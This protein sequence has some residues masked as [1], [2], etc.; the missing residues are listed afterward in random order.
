MTVRGKRTAT[1]VT[2]KPCKKC[3]CEERYTWRD[4]LACPQCASN[5]AKKYWRKKNNLPSPTRQETSNCEC[6]GR[7]G[8]ICLDHD[9]K[10]GEFRGWLCH[11]CNLGIGMLGDDIDGI[12]AALVYLEK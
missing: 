10:T 3:G 8:I 7:K 2:Y 4:K 9:H 11:A 5:N 1:R 12:K 6:C